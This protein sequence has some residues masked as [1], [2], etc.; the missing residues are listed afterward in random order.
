MDMERGLDE[1]TNKYNEVHQLIED[2][3]LRTKGRL[4]QTVELVRVRHE[5]VAVE[6]NFLQDIYDVKMPLIN[7]DFST[8]TEN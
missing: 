8:L 7:L 5:T 1:I 3:Y 2:N 6:L 4:I